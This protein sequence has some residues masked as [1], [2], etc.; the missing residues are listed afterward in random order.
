MGEAFLQN[1]GVSGALPCYVFH[2][3][4]LLMVVGVTT[5][6]EKNVVKYGLMC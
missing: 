2:Y 3:A 5:M 4:G 1:P 6:D